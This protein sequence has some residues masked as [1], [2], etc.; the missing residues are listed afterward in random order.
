MRD[1]IL[2][3]SYAAGSTLSRGP[4]ARA[5]TRRLTLSE[6]RNQLHAKS[7]ANVPQRDDRR[8]ALAELEPADI[9]TIDAHALSELGLRDTG[10]DPQPFDIPSYQVPHVV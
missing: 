7:L 6:E 4:G 3:R 2:V 8:V 5:R 1:G 10:S 9:G